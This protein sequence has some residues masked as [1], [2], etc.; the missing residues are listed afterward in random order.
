MTL[1]NG[2]GRNGNGHNGNG[3]SNGYQYVGTRPVR[4]DGVDKVTGRANFGADI[5]LNGMIYGSVVRSPHAHAKIKKINFDK[6]LK[7][8]GV[9]AVISGKDFPTLKPSDK[10][11][12]VAPLSFYDMSRNVIAR[13]KVLYDGHAIAAV[14]ATTQAIADKAAKL[15]DV[16]YKIL[17]PVMTAADAMKEKA[18]L[19][20]DD[21]FTEGVDPT[22]KK[23]SNIAKRTE[24]KL[25]DPE[26]A[27][28]SADF[29]VEGDYS[30][31]TVHQGYIEPHACAANFAQDG[32]VS[33]W[34]SSQGAFMIRAYT[35]RLCGMSTSKIKVIPAE[36]GGGFG[37]KTT[38]YLE[39][40]ALMLAKKSGRP[41]K[42]TMSRTEVMRATGPTSGGTAHVK[43]GA[44]KDGTLVAGTLELKYEAGAFPGSPVALGCMTG[45]APYDLK[46]VACLG[47][48]VV[49][50]RP[51]AAAYR[52]PG[53]PV[54]AYAVESAMDELAHKLGIDP[55]TLRRKNSAKEGT[56]AVY[57][58]EFDRIGNEDCLQ[59]A[60][61]T[62]HYNTPLGE[63]QGRGVASGFWF[64]I[65]G[66]SSAE[67]M[68]NE[69]GTVIVA[70]GSPDIG[71]SRAS[72]ALMAAEVLGVDVSRI[73][74]LVA[75]TE[76]VPY[77]DLTGGSRV[78]FATGKAVIDA[79]ED[80]IKDMK[81]RAAKVWKVDFDQVDWEN[82]S[83]ICIENDEIKPMSVADIAQIAGKTGGA[84]SGKANINVTKGAGPGFGTHIC[85]VEVDPETGRVTV[86][87]YTAIQDVG[88]AIHP[89]YV[90]GQL[91]GGAAQGIGWAL[92]EEYV[93]SKE[94]NLLNTGFLDYRVP[95]AS[96]LPMI[97][98]VLVEVPNAGHPFGVRGV[99]ET[100]IVPPLGAV[101]NAVSNAIGKRM[102]SLPMSPAKILQ[103]I[104]A[105]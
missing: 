99:G 30:T 91:Q 11:P 24:L 79:A 36:I 34:A 56:K 51:K 5:S 23:A 74:P 33:I 65:G 103:K 28:Q 102:T 44:K 26:V 66:T 89:S 82:G 61:K 35:A 7:L 19:L 86:L 58:V 71:G 80:A 43:I 60:Q 87:R 31:E 97:D 14:A 47:W 18:P 40:L 92:N 54:A 98:T 84:I 57:G 48:D 105:G 104:D 62:K 22:P 32:S 101:A 94:G 6:A 88:T 42:M 83:A 13:D 100:P 73:K 93:Y 53:A 68:I 46:D 49:V 69:D 9:K 64:N 16:E 85:D 72:M 3:T 75:D 50:N 78:T 63:N 17:K 55:L 12:G 38:I 4:P 21:L 67:V 39:P 2:N 45:F 1:Q 25:G 10:L 81:R 20:H 76:S 29:I 96:D 8:K 90:E 27:M 95:V 52:A 37:G 41:V 59:A 70:T 77:S 15:I